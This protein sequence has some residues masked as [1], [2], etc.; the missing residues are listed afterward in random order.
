[1]PGRV[2]VR[3]VAVPD[4]GVPADGPVGGDEPEEEEDD[5][6]VAAEERGGPAGGPRQGGRRQAAG[7]RVSRRG[8]G[9]RHPWCS[10]PGGPGAG[11]I[12]PGGRRRE[13]EFGRRH[14]PPHTCFRSAGG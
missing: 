10:R 1:D 13:D 7:E 2:V 6:A 5:D 12:T 8:V 4:G 3:R 14:F 9:G 11:S